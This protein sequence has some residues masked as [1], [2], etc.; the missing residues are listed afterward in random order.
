MPGNDPFQ[1]QMTTAFLL[2]AIVWTFWW[3]IS[4]K[5]VM[6][7]WLKP[8]YKTWT[9]YG[10]RLFFAANLIGA[11]VQFSIQIHKYPLS[12]HDALSVFEISLIMGV[13]I[14][15]MTVTTLKIAG[16]RDRKNL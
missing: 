3:N 10:F 4:W 13:V 14:G 12:I 6:R 1:Q 15:I 8:P 7:F 5:R 11:V 16:Y 2:T 9:Q